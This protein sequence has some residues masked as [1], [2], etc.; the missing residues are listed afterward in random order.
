VR[1]DRKA[2]SRARSAWTLPR[3]VIAFDE[4]LH[5]PIICVQC[6]A[7]VRHCPTSAGNEYVEHFDHNEASRIL[8]RRE[9]RKML[10]RDYIKVVYIDLTT[11]RIKI[12]R[13]QDLM[14]YIGGSGVATKLF[15]ELVRS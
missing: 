6:G 12:E 3:N 4:E 8:R 1:F 5:I 11:R 9:I 15:S 13:R 7:C 2:C 10:N 14:E